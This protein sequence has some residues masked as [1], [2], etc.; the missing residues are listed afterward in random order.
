MTKPLV[1][2]STL[3]LAILL[4]RTEPSVQASAAA[5]TST[6]S[7]TPA[8][9]QKALEVLQD[10]KKRAA[11]IETLQTIAKAA[12]SASAP[13]SRSPL[14][15]KP[16]SLGAQIL[17]QLSD[18]ITRLANEFTATA[19]GVTE[20]PILWRWLV[21]ELTNPAARAELLNAGWKLALV[22]GCA[23]GAEWLTRRA[24]RRPLVA[25]ESRAPS[26]DG[27]SH[28]DD[29]GNLAAAERHPRSARRHGQV[30]STWRLL[31]RLPFSFARLIL[32]LLPVAIFAALGNL[33]LA[34]EIGQPATTRLVILA[35]VNAYVLSRGIMCVVRMLIS[36][37]SARLR[38]LGIGDRQALYVEAWMRRITVV[39][40][41]GGALAEAELL[42]GL[43]PAAHDALVKMVALIVHLFLVIIVLQCRRSVAKRI[44]APAQAGGTLAL[45]RNWLARGWHYIAIFYIVGLW[46]V[47]AFGVRNGYSGLLRFCIITILV[48]IL[49]RLVAI[50]A[51]GALDR[52]FRINSDV[53]RRYPGLDRRASRY[54]LPL[55]RIVSGTIGV[56]TFLALLQA[57]GLDVL[58]WFH[59]GRTG[60]RL[61]S[62]LTTI[63]I[64]AAAAAVVWE[65]ANAAIERRLELL[66]RS[67]RATRLRTLLPL[68]RTA[69][70]VAI[71]IVIGLTALSELGVDI[72]PLLAGAGI[73]GV[74]IGFGSQTLVHDVIT[75]MFLLLENEVQVGDVITAAGFSGTVENLSI[76][77]IRLRA[78]D[79][80]VNIIPFSAVTTINNTSRGIGNAPISVTIP[81]DEDLDRVDATL[82]EIVGEMRKDPVFDGMIRG[83]LQLWGLDKVSAA[84]VTIVGQIE[85]TDAGRWPVQREFN[86]RMRER[87]QS[88]GIAIA[89]P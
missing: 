19:R 10:Q 88:Q 75:G 38:L 46:V 7:V 62:A 83:D 72:A 35:V 4:V 71:A 5:S 31:R 78:A 11:L 6:A 61:L 28:N 60:A 43:Y 79:G 76:R 54:Y 51:L 53:P 18:A 36:P 27:N 20:F 58:A 81:Y 74:A 14:P 17:L 24:V 37:S 67:G 48:V 49:A 32:E 41:F 30:A 84:G 80:S 82:N 47:W 34:S 57:W 77:T 70:L 33:L 21:H 86:R 12:P 50:V 56:L 69:L 59:N 13:A 64:A 87:F 45:L 39:A 68:L 73:I 65:G 8:Q 44:R 16:T 89:N 85:C 2:L 55:R 63:A 9:A 25:L 52:V 29:D 3:L 42:F 40:I 26:G 15:L 1:F 23:L 22:V 66:G